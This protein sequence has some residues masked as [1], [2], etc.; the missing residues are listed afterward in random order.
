MMPGLVALGRDTF[1]RA[2]AFSGL[3]PWPPRDMLAVMAALRPWMFAAPLC[4]SCAAAP[5]V[6][7]EA[8]PVKSACTAGSRA[9]ASVGLSVQQGRRHSEARTVT[10]TNVGESPRAVRVSQV[11]RAEGP[12]AGDWARQ[13][14]LGF[15][16]A[17]TDEAPREGLLAPGAQMA[18]RVGPQRT[19]GSWPCTKL[20]LALW[21]TVDD[22]PV[23][24]DAGIW[25]ASDEPAE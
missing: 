21:L 9:A 4:L 15:V 2:G 22:E 6:P 16:D 24:A 13:T 25:I 5:P 3:I 23:C 11:A 10:V 19:P 12:C 17:A 8:M 7:R 20:G 14:A 18:L 1:T